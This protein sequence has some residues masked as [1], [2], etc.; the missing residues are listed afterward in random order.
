MS[1]GSKE[2]SSK[3]GAFA[4]GG[5]NAMYSVSYPKSG[6]KSTAGTGKGAKQQKAGP[7]KPGTT[8]HDVKSDGGKFGKG[9]ATKMFGY[10]PSVPAKSGITSAR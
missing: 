3:A 1:N 7:Q 4:K 8:A 2:I 5:S 6:A 10:N 9:G